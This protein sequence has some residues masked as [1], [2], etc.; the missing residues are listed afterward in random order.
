MI[1]QELLTE[2]IRLS[3]ETAKAMKRTLSIRTLRAEL[4]ECCQGDE[5]CEITAQELVDF[6]T[7]F[8][9]RKEKE[10]E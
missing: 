2:L 4:L 6:F 8:A 1:D 3:K 7:F 10:N 5:D 9:S